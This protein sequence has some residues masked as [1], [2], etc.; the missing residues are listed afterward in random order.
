MRRRESEMPVGGGFP[1]ERACFRTNEEAMD[2]YTKVSGRVLARA[3]V[4]SERMIFWG[5]V[6]TSLVI[7]FAMLKGVFVI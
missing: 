3:D 2:A 4:L 6:S 5:L 7:S 1:F